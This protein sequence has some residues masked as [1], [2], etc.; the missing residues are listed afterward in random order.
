VGIVVAIATMIAAR[1]PALI[2]SVKNPAT[3][4]MN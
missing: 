2:P 1:T 3:G 4:I